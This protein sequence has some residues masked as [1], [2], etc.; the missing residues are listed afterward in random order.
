MIEGLKPCPVCKH[1][2]DIH[3]Y[4]EGLAR[5]DE[6]GF[7]FV[8]TMV[9]HCFECDYCGHYVENLTLGRA[10]EEWNS[11]KL[12]EWEKKQLANKQGE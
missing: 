12:S 1:V 8:D 2:D 7:W 6:N 9:S 4:Q 11:G 5:R 10:K 3:Y